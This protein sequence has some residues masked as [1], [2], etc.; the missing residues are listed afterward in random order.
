MIE[1]IQLDKSSSKHLYIQLYLQLRDLI[2]ASK[3]KEHTKLPPIRKLSK[4]LGVNNV[5]IVNAYNL[6]EEEN[7]VYKKVGSG[8]FV[9]AQNLVE[10]RE[11]IYLD[12]EVYIDEDTKF[13]EEREEIEDVEKLINFATAA[14]TPDLFPITPFKRL[15]NKVL[16]RDRGYAFGYQKSQGYL[17]LRQSISEY[18]KRYNIESN[19][20]EIQIVSGAQQGID[21]LAKTFLDYGDTVFVERPT[22]P[23]AISVFKSRRANIID[24][25]M[26]RDG[27]DIEVLE[28]EL[29]KEKPKF[30]YLMPNYQNPT[31]Y[32]YSQEKKERIL[33]LAKEHDLL[34]IEDDCLSDLNYGNSNNLSLKSLSDNGR[35]IYIK[36]FSKIFMPGLRLA[37]LIIPERYFNDILLS[38]YMSDIFTDGLVQRVLDLYFR[39]EIWEDQISKLRQTYQKRYKAMINALHKYL[40][41]RVKFTTP[42]G[43]LNLWLELPEN[44]SGKKL[45]QKALK[46]GINI[47]PG[48]VFYYSQK[49]ENRVRLSIAAVTGEQIER[50]VKSLAKLIEDELD[51]ES[52]HWDNSIMPLV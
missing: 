36:S 14:P 39:E 44:I 32:S 48:E 10:D 51:E 27:I 40:P 1:S 35:V 47:A 18:I 3:L 52:Y 37:F 2:E 11:D 31:G 28:A 22:Y 13:I 23:G 6:L 29:S 15:L 19:I 41:Q 16:D 26:K 49:K 45:H 17:P 21:I 42:A 50:G 20:D 8:T 9:A 33:E 5:T 24:I 46:L 4:S 30:L 38:K 25:P 34:I 7:L 12:E 43:G